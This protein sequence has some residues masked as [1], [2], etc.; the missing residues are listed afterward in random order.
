MHPI[1]KRTLV[2]L[3]L[4]NVSIFVVLLANAAVKCRGNIWKMIV[5]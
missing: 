3:V 4:K 1:P 5:S 2:H